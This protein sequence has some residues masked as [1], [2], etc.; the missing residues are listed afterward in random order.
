MSGAATNITGPASTRRSWEGSRVGIRE[1][2][3]TL[4]ETRTNSWTVKWLAVLTHQVCVH[5]LVLAKIRHLKRPSNR[6]R[7]S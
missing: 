1:K 6:W 3:H 7:T 5:P 2:Q 4:S